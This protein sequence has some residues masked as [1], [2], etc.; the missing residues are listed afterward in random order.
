MFDLGSIYFGFFL[1]VFPL[2]LVKVIRQT[3][4]ILAQSRTWRNAYLYMIWIEAL[5]NLVFAIVTYLYLTDVIHGNP[6]FYFG[7][8]GLWAIQT[9]LLSQIIAN[10]VSLI[11]V[12][13]RKAQLLKW[14]LFGLIGCVNIAVATIWPAAYKT[15][16]TATEKFINVVFEKVEKSFFLV[17][18]LGLNLLFLYLVRY[19]LISYGLNK[20]WLLFK[21]NVG[22]VVL[23]TG[24]DA[25]LLG[26]L[27]LPATY[28]YVQFAPSVYIVKLHIELT[29]AAL[30]AKI[31]RK[32]VTNARANPVYAHPS[33]RSQGKSYSQVLEPASHHRCG[34]TQSSTATDSGTFGND[35]EIQKTDSTC[36][37][38]LTYYAGK[39][40]I[41]KTVTTTVSSADHAREQQQQQHHHHHHH[42]ADLSI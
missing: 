28:L 21:F 18:D 3:R 8:V 23:S 15:D 16:A 22:L 2:T 36:D 4:K 5:V 31:V 30:I 42:K 7:T 14:G 35:V 24:M 13:K 38:P 29:M 1:G 32:S 27:S 20:Y 25:A 10:R 40:G 11:M 19:R 37:I 34:G 17:V 39:A 41:V 6:A 9:Q 12:N 26:M 33:G